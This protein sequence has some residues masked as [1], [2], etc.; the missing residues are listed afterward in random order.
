MTIP[1][2][3]PGTR[4]LTAMCALALT[5]FALSVSA[6]SA[7]SSDVIRVKGGVAAFQARGD[8]LKVKDT[9]RDGLGVQARLFAGKRPGLVLMGVVTDRNGADNGV[10]RKRLGLRE[11]VQVWLQICYQDHGHN[12]VRCS[13]LEPATS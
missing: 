11:S 12:N 1:T 13:R 6:A 3:T 8:V 9:R 4:N 7:G 2:T 5:L 10:K